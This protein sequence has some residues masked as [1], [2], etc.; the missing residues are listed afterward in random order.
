VHACLYVSH[1]SDLV[2]YS[3]NVGILLLLGRLKVCPEL[4]YHCICKLG[5]VII[6]IIFHFL[7]I[8]T[9]KQAHI[10]THTH[11]FQTHIVG[12]PVSI[13]I[14][15]WVEVEVE[16]IIYHSLSQFINLHFLNLTIQSCNHIICNLY[17]VD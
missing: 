17:M 15:T 10:H 5:S 16:A 4:M 6:I 13:F 1:I 2:I 12:H 8:R 7:R 3:V 9:L 14:F 11:I